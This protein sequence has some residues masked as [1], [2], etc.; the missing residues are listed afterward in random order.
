[1]A[2]ATVISLSNR[3]SGI[4]WLNRRVGRLALSENVLIIL[5]LRKFFAK[6][7]KK[8]LGTTCA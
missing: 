1:M 3:W 5:P 7:T 6:H 4:P 2:N 8:R